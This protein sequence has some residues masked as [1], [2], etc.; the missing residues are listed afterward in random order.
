[1]IHLTAETPIQLATQP[2]DFRKG[3]DGVVA[4]CRDH[5]Q[6]NPRSGCLFVFVNRSRTMMRV[7]AYEHNGYWLMTKRLSKGRFPTFTSC[8]FPI[9]GIASSELRRLLLGL[10]L[11]ESNV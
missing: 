6:Q 1:M 3:I 5:L 10:C 8:Q 11:Q 9:E 4:V 2:L 7:L